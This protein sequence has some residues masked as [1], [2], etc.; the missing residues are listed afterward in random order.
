MEYRLVL[1][2]KEEIIGD[3]SPSDLLPFTNVLKESLIIDTEGAEWMTGNSTQLYFNIYPP[4][5]YLSLMDK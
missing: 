4:Y 2:D 3:F 5:F 1:D